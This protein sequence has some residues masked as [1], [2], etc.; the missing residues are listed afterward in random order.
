MKQWD[1]KGKREIIMKIK[2]HHFMDIIK[3]HGAGLMHFVPDEKMGHDFYQVG[4]E[5]LKNPQLELCLTI[6]ADDICKPC[7]VCQDGVCIDSLSGIADFTKKDL[8]NK[9]LDRRI[10]NLHQLDEA[11]S[12]TA[13]QLCKIFLSNDSF[14]F[15]VW[16]EEQEEATS[17][18]HE[19]FV[20][21]AKQYLGL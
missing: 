17:R 12:Y 15:E 7:K 18:R 8:Y 5:V 16:Q 2:P 20:K 6:E 4:N 10:I 9:E 1:E 11:H 21:G 13:Q 3:L 19:L 14:I